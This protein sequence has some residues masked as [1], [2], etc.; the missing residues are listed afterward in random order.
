VLNVKN[1]QVLKVT[2]D[3]RLGVNQGWTCV[4]GRFGFDYVHSPDRLTEPMIREK[5]EL[6]PA[7]WD[8]ALKRVVKGLQKVKEKHG[9][10]A[11]GFLASAKCTNEENYLLQRMAR[12]AVGT[13]SVDHCA[14]L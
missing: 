7:S 4:K 9:P 10:E 2:S 8:E 14:R 12:A 5:G 3:E 6:R 11:I 1:Q 13:N